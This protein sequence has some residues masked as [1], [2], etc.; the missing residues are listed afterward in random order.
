ML[1]RFSC[2]GPQALGAR[3][4]HLVTV[5]CLCMMALHCLRCF[6][7]I[8]V[9]G[10]PNSSACWVSISGSGGA[11]T[12]LP[13]VSHLFP[14]RLPVVSNLVS[15]FLPLVTSCFLFSPSCPHLSCACLSLVSRSHLA[16][17]CLLLVSGLFVCRL[18]TTCLPIVSHVFLT[19][20]SEIGPLTAV[21]LQNW[22]NPGTSR[23][24]YESQRLCPERS[25]LEGS[26]RVLD[27]AIFEVG[28]VGP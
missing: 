17:S 19:Y 11:P 10:V 26:G 1:S 3:I 9:A 27:G 4:C 16:P 24:D 2:D 14:A 5:C 6:G 20:T 22:V 23:F 12:C 21:G 8:S 13:V 7:Q 18:S 15:H 28:H 25:E